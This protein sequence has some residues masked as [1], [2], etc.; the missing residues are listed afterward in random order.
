M[1][2]RGLHLTIFVLFCVQLLSGTS[3]CQNDEQAIIHLQNGIDYFHAGNLEEAEAQF[4]AAL[5]LD[6]ELSIAHYNLGVIEYWKGKFE[7]AREFFKNAIKI[8]KEQP[9]YHFNLGLT[10]F[11]LEDYKDASKQ[12]EK[13][14]ELDSTD[15]EIYYNLAISYRKRGEHRKAEDAYE[16]CIQLQSRVDEGSNF[17]I[18]PLSDE[19]PYSHE[20]QIEDDIPI[21]IEPE[22]SEVDTAMEVGK[23]ED[24]Y[25]SKTLQVGFAAGPGF[26][27]N[28][29]F[30]QVSVSPDR[31]SFSAFVAM[32]FPRKSNFLEAFGGDGYGFAL[33]GRYSAKTT[34]E[35]KWKEYCLAANIRVFENLDKSGKGK[36]FISFGPGIYLVDAELIAVDESNSQFGIEGGAG[37]DYLLLKIISFHAEASYAFT[38][39]GDNQHTNSSGYVHFGLSFHL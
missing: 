24:Q 2:Y 10:Y 27:E 14:A 29:Y 32:A 33:K 15:A 26:P 8:K 17:R 9:K 6:P 18:R 28:Y 34:G 11:Q 37:I 19:I 20:A 16:K 35:Q 25:F 5:E 22:E 31:I 21:E 3:F 7:D 36:F 38:Y 13:A 1:F 12:F 39:H 4:T 23:E 30:K